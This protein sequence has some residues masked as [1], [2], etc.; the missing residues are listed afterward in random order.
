MMKNHHLARGIG[1][2]GWR[3]FI[4]KLEYKAAG[5]GI[6]MVKLDQWFAS[7]KPVTAAVIKCRKCR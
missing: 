6:H 7:T 1:D 2:A 3:G 5:K 4:L